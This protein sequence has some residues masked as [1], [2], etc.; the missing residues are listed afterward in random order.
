MNYDDEFTKSFEEKFQHH[1][2]LIREMPPEV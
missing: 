1:L 2:K